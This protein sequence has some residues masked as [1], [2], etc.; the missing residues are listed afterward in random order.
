MASIGKRLDLEV[1]DDSISDGL[2]IGGE[3]RATVR[4]ERLVFAG[5]TVSKVHVPDMVPS[6]R[7]H[8]VS[9]DEAMIG[10]VGIRA[11]ADAFKP[12]V[13]LVW[14]ERELRPWAACDP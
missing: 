4:S 5:A 6:L 9:I 11:I 8:T 1:L 12:L 7:D 10:M 2:S 13:D 3:L 14:L